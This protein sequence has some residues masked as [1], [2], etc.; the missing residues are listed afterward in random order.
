M[1]P[2]G[3]GTGDPDDDARP[4]RIR[5][6]TA[7]AGGPAP[8]AEGDLLQ[9]TRD[10]DIEAMTMFLEEAETHVLFSVNATDRF[11]RSLLWYACT[12]GHLEAVRLLVDRGANV[13][14]CDLIGWQ[15]LHLACH[16]GHPEIAKLL[17]DYGSEHDVKTYAG[18]TPRWLAHSNAKPGCGKYSEKHAQIAAHLEQLGGTLGLPPA[19]W[20]HPRRPRVK[21]KIPP[22]EIRVNLEDGERYCI[23]ELIQRYVVKEEMY[24]EEECENFFR[25]TMVMP[26]ENHAAWM[27]PPAPRFPLGENKYG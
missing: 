8:R 20:V 7:P 18:Q 16:H 25:D 26:A 14:V 19:E 12:N 27:L 2:G 11:G 1:P 15:P 21:R 24:T 22:D 23:S 6:P 9:A 5:R 10:G 3:K 13:H 4:R 17:L